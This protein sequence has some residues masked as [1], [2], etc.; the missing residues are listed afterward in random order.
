MSPEDESAGLRE[1]EPNFEANPAE[2]EYGND[3]ADRE[4]RVLHHN[5]QHRQ[6]IQGCEENNLAWA[7]V[8][9]C[10]LSGGQEAGVSAPFTPSLP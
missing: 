4:P 6:T 2:H 9:E 1:P 5:P 7:S 3:H 10:P 8:R